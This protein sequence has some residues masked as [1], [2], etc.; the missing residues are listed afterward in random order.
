MM[1]NASVLISLALAVL[2]AFGLTFQQ[3][4]MME[5]GLD[6]TQFIQPIDHTFF[7]GF[8]SVTLMGFTGFIYLF[9]SAASIVLAAEIAI[10]ANNWI[11]HSRYQWIKSHFNIAVTGTDKESSFLKFSTKLMLYISL[12]FIVLILIIF[13]LQTSDK[14]GRKYSKTFI[15]NTKNNKKDRKSIRFN[16]GSDT[17]EGYTIICSGLQCAYLVKGKSVVLNHRDIKSVTNLGKI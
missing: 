4:F 11:Q 5:L 8:I 3:G 10:V 15:E 14:A 17:I 16:D 1:R 2:Y 12:I 9:L 13:S 7:S 6:E